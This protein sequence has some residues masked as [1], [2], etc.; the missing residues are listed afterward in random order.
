[1]DLTLI[2]IA[3][4]IILIAHFIKGF[5]GFGSAL[6]A[7]PLLVFFFDI[8]FAIPVF[9]VNDITGSTIMCLRERGHVNKEVLWVIVLGLLMG[10]V[11]GGIF[12]STTNSETLL[13]LFGMVV[14]AMAL[15]IFITRNKR[16][17]ITRKK[18]WGLVT[19]WVAGLCQV[20]FG[21]G[22]PP[23]VYYT[24]QTSRNKTQLRA[25][26]Y[27]IFYAASIFQ[28]ITYVLI[29]IM[30]TSVIL[31]SVQ[32]IP[33]M[34]LGLFLGNRF[35]FRVDEERFRTAITAIILLMGLFIV[36]R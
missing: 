5:S 20:S 22:G 3:G 7:L 13:K 18:L 27:S 35:F 23:A 10:S 30:T 34:L 21:I 14:M 9:L 19:G 2:A 11:L 17:R 26:L 31:F 32:L 29:G 6:V 25:T 16:S 12:I 1:M 24:A 8:K 36:L 15:H 33:F 4:I 28:F